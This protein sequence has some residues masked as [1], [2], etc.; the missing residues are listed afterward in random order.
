MRLH[1]RRISRLE[2]RRQFLLARIEA[3]EAT[4]KELTYDRAEASALK[5]AIEELLLIYPDARADLNAEMLI[6]NGASAAE[7][8]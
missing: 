3:G 8:G 4:G 5:W 2:R 1:A 7:D 6:L